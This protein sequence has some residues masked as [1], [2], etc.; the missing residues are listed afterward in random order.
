MGIIACHDYN[1]P[2][3]HGA[4]AAIDKFLL[5]NPNCKKVLNPYDLDKSIFLQKIL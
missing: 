5:E 2:S 1:Y 4:N 3:C